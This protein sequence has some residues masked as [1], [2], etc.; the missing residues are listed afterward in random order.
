M[1]ETFFR[2]LGLIWA[3]RKMRNRFLF[4][5]GALFVYRLLANIPVPDVDKLALSNFIG[6]NQI[7]G[8]VDMISGGG[9]S[10]VSIMMLGVGPYIT[11]SIIL[12]L[13]TM[14][15]PAL[16]AMTNEEGEIGRKKFSQWTRLLSIPLALIQ[17][18]G[19][20]FLLKNQGVFPADLTAFAFALNVIV[21]SAGSV[22][23]M[24]IGELI[25]EFGIGN[26]VSLIIFAGIVSRLPQA[27]T[28]IDTSNIPM[29][30]V[31]AVMALLVIAGVVFVTEGERPI[32]VTYAKQVRGQSTTGGVSTYIP[33]RINQAGVIP[34][35]FA[36]SILAFPQM[37]AQFLASSTSETVTLIAEK[38]NW[39]MNDQWA[40]GITYFVLVVLF[41]YFYTAMTFDPDQMASNLQKNGA[42][43]PG[44]RP[45]APTAE[46][47]G[48]VI[49]RITLVGAL[50][51]GIIAILPLL[52]K[53]WS[54]VSSLVIG[55][56]GLLIVVSVVSDLV[57]KTEAQLTMREY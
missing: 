18:V 23:L 33:L 28:T 22:L 3:D 1:I 40:Y 32:P 46:Y 43:V 19:Y 21:I 38:I 57:K 24:W 49:V 7:F 10:A 56:T 13:L 51:L 26:G 45:G 54:G 4:V 52:V 8:I 36:M 2:K 42:F 47:V 55:G 17:A 11:A 37:I 25:S 31:F 27:L 48:N 6:S 14:M 50:F 29:M 20:L 34:I 39:F 35:I 30:V 44:V 41:T 5:L 15:V 16:K 53:A 12:Q 9:L